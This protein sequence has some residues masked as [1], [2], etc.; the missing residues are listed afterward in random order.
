LHAFVPVAADKEQA[1]EKCQKAHCDGHRTPGSKMHSLVRVWFG[2]CAEFGHL[3]L[4]HSC[5][6][7]NQ[8]NWRLFR[9]APCSLPAGIPAINIRRV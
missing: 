8:E 9:T 7:E 4:L 2:F 5:M 1:A 3:I 6:Q